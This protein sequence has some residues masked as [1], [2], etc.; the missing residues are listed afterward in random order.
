MTKIYTK[1]GDKGD[2][3]RFDG[4][5][6]RKDNIIIKLNGIVDECSCIIGLAIASSSNSDIDKILTDIQKKLFIVGSE[7]SSCG[8]KISIKIEASDIKKLE[9]IIDSC[10]KELP[11]LTN[12]ILPGGSLPSSYLHLSRAKSREVERCLAS[13][14]D[15]W[16]SKSNLNAYMNRLSDA[17]FVLARVTNKKNSV[18]DMIW[19]IKN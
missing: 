15:E 1:N 19:N 6:V 14:S 9:D 13:I 17:L 4:N 12:F 18:A 8:K 10:E 2:T 3:T 16:I 11:P 5:R 7:V